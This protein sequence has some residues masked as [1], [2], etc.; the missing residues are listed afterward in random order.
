MELV[1][2]DSLTADGLR[3]NPA[4][5]WE[6]TARLLS[7]KL[8]IMSDSEPRQVY[9]AEQSVEPEGFDSTHMQIMEKEF[10]EEFENMRSKARNL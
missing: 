7:A 6:T 4:L 8:A 5:N 2:Q 1:L 10:K 9:C 3:A